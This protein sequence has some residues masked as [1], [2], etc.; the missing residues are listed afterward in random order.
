MKLLS[1]LA[2]QGIVMLAGLTLNVASPAAWLMVT[3]AV[4]LA[5]SV[6][7]NCFVRVL[8][9]VFSAIPVKVM[10]NANSAAEPGSPVMVPPFVEM[11]LMPAAV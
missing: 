9:D 7:I 2:S 1:S 5:L 6:T 3:V 10:L 4:L 8:T 11:P